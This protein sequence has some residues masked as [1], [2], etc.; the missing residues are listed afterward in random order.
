MVGAI[1]AQIQPFR[2]TSKT[3]EPIAGPETFST[4]LFIQFYTLRQK[5]N[6]EGLIDRMKKT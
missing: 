6:F 5:K 2:I 4:L 3:I 1:F